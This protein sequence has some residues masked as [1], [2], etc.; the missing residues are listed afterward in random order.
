[1]DYSQK[2]TDLTILLNDLV[3]INNDRF[4][5]YR[6]AEQQAKDNTDLQ[7]IFKDKSHQSLDFTTVLKH[8][9]EKLGHNYNNDTTFAGKVFRTWMDIKNTFKP[10]NATSILDS[11][12]FGED[13]AIKAYDNALKSDTEISAE[14]RQH[15]LEQQTAIK[16]SYD[17]IR[18]YRDLNLNLF[19][20]NKGFTS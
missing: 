17:L 16:K 3:K 9:I 10:N 2:N 14:I 13:A 15:I 18:R 8:Y 11:C 7:S 12:E 4:E 5:G 20:Y 6:K 1:M 19:K